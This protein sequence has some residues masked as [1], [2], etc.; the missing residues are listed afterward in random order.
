MTGGLVS[1]LVGIVFVLPGLYID[2]FEACL[3]CYK[4][5]LG[6]EQGGKEIPRYA[7]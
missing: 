3:L 7:K 6:T 1:G 2:I 4:K 5:E